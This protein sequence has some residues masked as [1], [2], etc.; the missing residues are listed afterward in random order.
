[1]S[2]AT[3]SKIS[4]CS[5]AETAPRD[6]VEAPSAIEAHAKG[7][8]ANDHAVVAAPRSLT[9]A[10]QIAYTISRAQ[11]A[12]NSPCPLTTAQMW[13]I[14]YPKLRQLA[15]GMC[16]YERPGHTLPP[17]AV[18]NETCARFMEGNPQINNPLHFACHV[19]TEMR[20][21]LV[22]HARTR[23][24]AK[25]QRPTVDELRVLTT[26]SHDDADAV[27]VMDIDIALR[28]LEKVSPHSADIAQLYY[29]FAPSNLEIAVLL[30]VSEASVDRT[31]RFVK[32]WLE[33]YVRNLGIK[34]T[35][36]RDSD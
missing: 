20:R 33:R 30:G 28:E 11:V 31:V 8:P 15:R 12:A 10:Q 29:F 14:A 36:E 4:L 6:R 7:A 18:V 17:T 25:R 22:D 5:I 16:H 35:Q 1:M 3:V 9:I 21:T 24:R 13:S 27:D 2:A 23:S 34:A 26:G 32:A 19:A